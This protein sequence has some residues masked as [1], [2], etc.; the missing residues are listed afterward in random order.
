MKI[1]KTFANKAKQL[2]YERVIE[3]KKI[4]IK[5]FENILGCAVGYGCVNPQDEFGSVG[6]RFKITKKGRK[7]LKKLKVVANWH[8]TKLGYMSCGNK[9][10]IILKVLRK[11]PVL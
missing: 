8:E 5:E 6:F 4:D 7:I 2:L 10:P 1:E 9:I 11:E 3:K